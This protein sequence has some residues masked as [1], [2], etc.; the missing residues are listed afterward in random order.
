MECRRQIVAAMSPKERLAL[1][2]DLTWKAA[3]EA[4]MN[5]SR[6]LLILLRKNVNPGKNPL[7]ALHFLKLYHHCEQAL[8][9]R[10]DFPEVARIMFN[11]KRAL[12]IAPK[13]KRTPEH[14]TARE[15]ALKARESGALYF[16]KHGKH[17]GPRPA[18]RKNIANSN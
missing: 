18:K 9:E 6:Q 1:M 4:D 8:E 17:Y 2:Y 15:K 16:G 3:N 7:V 12:T 10:E 14:D 11:L 5:R 13:R